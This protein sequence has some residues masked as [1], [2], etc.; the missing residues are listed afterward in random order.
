V[1]RCVVNI[2]KERLAFC[3]RD[4]HSDRTGFYADSTLK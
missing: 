4:N 3:V 2:H 1:P